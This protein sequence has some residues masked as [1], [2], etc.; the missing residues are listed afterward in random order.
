MPAHQHQ[1]RTTIRWDDNGGGG[2]RQYPAY[3]RAFR[4]H[5]DG[6]PALEGSADAA[7][8]GDA[9]RH[10]PED[11]LL[12]AVA[13]C[14]MLSFLALCA[15]RHVDVQAYVDEAQGSMTTHPDRGGRFTGIVLHPRVCLADIAQQS[16]ALELHEAAHRLCFI[17]NSCNFPIALRPVFEADDPASA[18]AP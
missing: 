5:I 8:C 3:S 1:Y 9:A 2:T 16:L 11:L 7:F 13:S 12:V 17:A 15:R 10:N 18:G 14:H 4:A 6:K